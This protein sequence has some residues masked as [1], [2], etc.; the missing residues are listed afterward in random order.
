[1]VESL[2]EDGIFDVGLTDPSSPHQRLYAV[3]P[4]GKTL[5][6]AYMP[7]VASISVRLQYQYCPASVLTA[8]ALVPAE[9]SFWVLALGV[10]CLLEG[11]HT[12]VFFPQCLVWSGTWLLRIW[13][14]FPLTAPAEHQSSILHLQVLEENDWHTE[15]LSGIW[16]SPK[17]KTSLLG[18]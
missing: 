6:C 10:T 18:D 17:C 11:P 5:N 4:C 8:S 16:L 1:M 7:G 9:L 13:R 14:N 15:H 3:F 2:V 12:E